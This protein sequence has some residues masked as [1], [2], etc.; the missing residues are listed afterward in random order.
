MRWLIFCAT[1]I[2]T[3]FAANY[4]LE[5]FVCG[6]GRIA[7]FIPVVATVICTF[8]A[9]LVS[10]VASVHWH[11]SP[12]SSRQQRAAFAIVITVYCLIYAPP[13][14]FDFDQNA[15][16][17]F[18][19]LTQAATNAAVIPQSVSDPKRVG[20][21]ASSA[22]YGM[23]FTRFDVISIYGVTGRESQDRIL[24]T[25]GDYHRIHSTRPLHVQFYERENWSTWQGANGVS[26]GRRGPE[27]VV[28]CA[29]IR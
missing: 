12:F 7:F 14:I 26:G 23:F 13:R 1:L 28:R 27:K 21:F 19:A 10:R 2:A 5:R 6:D 3:T 24:Q 16:D 17:Q 25:F 22:W 18:E 9:L 15:S 20:V 11:Q 4:A 29:V 8:T